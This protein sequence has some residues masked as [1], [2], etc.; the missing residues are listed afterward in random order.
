MWSIEFDPATR[1]MTIRLVHF[2]TP[3]QMRALARAH[4]QALSATA[5]SPFRVLADLR[6]ARPFEREAA[7]VFSEIRRAALAAP[8]FRRRAV[9]TDSP[10]VAMQQRR[11]II[12]DAIA[13]KREIVTLDEAEARTFLGPF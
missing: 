12:D 4:A 7:T 13:A 6:G 2:A 3:S 9:L 1:V 10:T 11:A 8:G 5:A